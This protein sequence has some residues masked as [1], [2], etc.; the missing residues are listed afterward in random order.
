VGDQHRSDVLGARGVGIHAV[1]IDRGGYHPEA[2]DCTRIASLSDL[3]AILAAA[4][5][6]LHPAKHRRIGQLQDQ[7]EE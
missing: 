1:L 6:S 5:H 3:A 4:P 2:N 7:V